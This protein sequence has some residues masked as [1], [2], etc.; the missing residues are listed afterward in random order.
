M[1]RTISNSASEYRLSILLMVI[2]IGVLYVFFCSGCIPASLAE[3]GY[4]YLPNCTLY[5]C[6]DVIQDVIDNCQDTHENTNELWEEY[7]RE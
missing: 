4:S 2:I 3:L 7:I 6:T 1:K 5:D